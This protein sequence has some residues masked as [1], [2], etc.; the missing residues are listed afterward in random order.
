MPVA[1][2]RDEE[3]P[4]RTELEPHIQ[5]VELFEEIVER[6]CSYDATRTHCYAAPEPPTGRAQG[7]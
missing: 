1:F 5:D 6:D 7:T 3:R 4:D 2:G